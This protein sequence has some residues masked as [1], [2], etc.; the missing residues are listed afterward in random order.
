MTRLPKEFEGIK[1]SSGSHKSLAAEMHSLF[2]A[3]KKPLIDRLEKIVA[4]PNSRAKFVIAA[5]VFQ[6]LLGMSVI[7][8]PME[9]LEKNL[10]GINSD[11]DKINFYFWRADADFQIHLRS[12]SG[13]LETPEKLFSAICEAYQLADTHVSK[14]FKGKNPRRSNLNARVYFDGW[15]F[16]CAR[17]LHEIW[18]ENLITGRVSK[19][20]P[21]GPRADMSSELSNL[22][23]EGHVLTEADIDHFINK[24]I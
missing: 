10:P 19:G 12:T 11:R 3:E 4:D 20:V 15:R 1:A 24:L 16:G 23:E 7:S 9:T 22:F 13:V 8:I 17:V 6:T 2:M 14:V 5:D 21:K 18:P